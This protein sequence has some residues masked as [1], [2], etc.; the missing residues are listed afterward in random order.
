[1]PCGVRLRIVRWICAWVVAP[2]HM[3]HASDSQPSIDGRSR[4]PMA[5]RLWVNWS[6]DGHATRS[7][8]DDCG[9]SHDGIAPSRAMSERGAA[10]ASPPVRN[11]S[12]A[13]PPS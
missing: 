1:M 2:A 9:I 6:R 3:S 7:D 10:A 8:H 5:R 11:D 13:R 12:F 4:Q